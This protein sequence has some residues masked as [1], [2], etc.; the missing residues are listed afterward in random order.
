MKRDNTLAKIFN[1]QPIR[2][3]RKEPHKLYFRILEKSSRIIGCMLEKYDK[4]EFNHFDVSFQNYGISTKNNDLFIK[5][6]NSLTL[7]FERHSLDIKYVWIR[8]NSH[9]GNGH[10]YIVFLLSNAQNGINSSKILNKTSELWMKILKT[11]SSGIVNFS[12]TNNGII[13][14]RNTVD[15]MNTIEKCIFIV[16]SHAKVVNNRFCPSGIRQCGF[17][18]LGDK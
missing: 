18:R 8:V 3:A 12:L 5:F 6:I 7:Y 1:F 14:D 4:L 10:Q 17:S 15:Y 11:E 2:K 16:S 9:S 13:L